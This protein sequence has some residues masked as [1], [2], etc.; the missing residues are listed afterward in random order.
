[1]N[2]EI[3]APRQVGARKDTPSVG[4]RH[5]SAEAILR[6]PIKIAAPRQVGARKDAPSVGARHNS[7]EVIAGGQW[8]CRASLA[9]TPSFVFARL[10]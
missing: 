10:T 6:G 8:D 2:Y 7:T 3:A 1:M 9:M 4:A 5:D